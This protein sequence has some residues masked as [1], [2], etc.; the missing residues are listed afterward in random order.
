MKQWECQVTKYERVSTETA[1]LHVAGWRCE[2]LHRA[3]RLIGGVTLRSP[4]KGRDTLDLCLLHERRRF[5]AIRGFSKQPDIKSGSTPVA[6]ERRSS[7][8]RFTLKLDAFVAPIIDIASRPRRNSTGRRGFGRD[9]SLRFGSRSRFFSPK[10]ARSTPQLQTD[11]AVE[12]GASVALAGRR[13]L[14]SGPIG[15]SIKPLL[16]GRSQHILGAIRRKRGSFLAHEIGQSGV[17]QNWHRRASGVSA[18]TGGRKA[19]P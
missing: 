3:C 18:R 4:A 5:R 7:P 8:R 2:A 16:Q 9:Y 10:S 11:R 17:P 1:P 15:K 19:C 14:G 13:P 6:V 12:T